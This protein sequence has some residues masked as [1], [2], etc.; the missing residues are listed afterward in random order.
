MKKKKT[1]F[2]KFLESI[3]SVFKPRKKKKQLKIWFINTDK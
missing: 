3:R 1:G 2:E